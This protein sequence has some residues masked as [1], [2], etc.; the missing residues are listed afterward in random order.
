MLCPGLRIKFRDE[1]K[2]ETQEW[3][4]EDGISDYLKQSLHDL[5]VMPENPIV[6]NFAAEN[7]AAEWALAWVEEGA[8]W[9][10]ES[11]VNLI[12]TLTG[13]HTC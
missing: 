9:I 7:E 11:Y 13:R 3:Y 1:A 8:D 4:F 6:G 12:P 10:A 5:P 2:K